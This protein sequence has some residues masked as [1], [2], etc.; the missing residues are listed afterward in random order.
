MKIE[1]LYNH[2]KDVNGCW[3]WQRSIDNSG[4]GRVNIDGKIW[5]THRLSWTIH[6]GPIPKTTSGRGMSVCHKCDNPKCINPDHLF[7]GTDKDNVHD[8]IHKNR[9]ADQKG[10]NNP[11]RIL[12]EQD[13]RDI[14]SMPGP[15]RVIA[16]RYGVSKYCIDEI[17]A[18]TTWKHI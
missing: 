10:M 14:R 13:V 16:A 12:T 3:E 1:D 9:R 15:H 2:I 11:N 6:N 18:R 17:R 8:A 7:L 5:L 4:Y